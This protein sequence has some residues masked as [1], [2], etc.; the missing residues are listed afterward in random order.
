MLS[1]LPREDDQAHKRPFATTDRLSSAKRRRT[2]DA[3][4][5]TVGIDSRVFVG[6]LASAAIGGMTDTLGLMAADAS[7]KHIEAALCRV[8]DKPKAVQRIC[9]AV[10]TI[11][12]AHRILCLAATQDARRSIAAIVDGPCSTRD[13]TLALSTLVVAG[14][15]DAVMAIVDACTATQVRLQECIPRDALCGAARHGAPKM[16]DRLVSSC[17]KVAARQALVYLANERRAFEALWAC[18][19]LCARDLV[20]AVGTG[21]T[22]AIFLQ[23]AIASGCCDRCAIMSRASSRDNLSPFVGAARDCATEH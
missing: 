8:V 20:H 23:E 14:D 18:A 5:L 7:D 1:M 9:D 16:V 15:F 11:K 4:N 10:G 21:T 13:I 22:G 2:D 12:D 3:H 17:D 19:G 6:F